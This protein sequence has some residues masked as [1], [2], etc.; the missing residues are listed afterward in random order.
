MEHENDSRQKRLVMRLAGATA[1]MV[2]AITLIGA[3]YALAGH[4]SEVIGACFG[5]KGKVWLAD[6]EDECEAKTEFREWNVEGPQ[7]PTGPAGPS[8]PQGPPGVPGP[9]GPQGAQGEQGIQGP[10]GPAGGL[11]GYQIVT[12]YDE[13]ESVILL[14][15]G[16]HT[17]AAQCPVGKVVIGGGAQALYE[18]NPIIGPDRPQLALV[19]SNSL[20]TNNFAGWIARWELPAGDVIPEGTPFIVKAICVDA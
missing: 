2:G 7:G 18:A 12:E 19:D 6:S 14:N 11:A 8:G 3:G 20:V 16:E 9:Q 15:N 4:D 5:E 1:A 10:A 13:F 17:V